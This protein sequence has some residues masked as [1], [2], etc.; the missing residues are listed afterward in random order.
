M[1][2][3]INPVELLQALIRFDTTNPPGNEQECIKYIYNLLTDAGLNPSL[4]SL[5]PNRPNLVCTLKGQ[6]K[7]SPLL[8]YGHSDVVTTKGQI[9]KHPPFEG[10]IDGGCIWGRGALDMKGGIV[11]MITALLKVKAE[12]IN[13]PGDV[14]LAVVSDEENGGIYGAK[15]LVENYPNLF[16]G[17]KYAIGEAGG[18]SIYISGKKFYPVMV[19]E[20]Q[21][22]WLKLTLRGPG[23]HGSMPIRGGAMAKLG[24]ILNILDK[25][26][27]PV[28]MTTTTMEMLKRVQSALPFPQNQVVKGMMNPALSNKIL[29]LMGERGKLFDPMLRNTVSPTIVNGG[30]KVNVIPS[31]ITLQADGRLL[32]GF[33][34]ENMLSELRDILG[35]GVEIEVLKYDQGPPEPDMEKFPLLEDILRKADPEGIPIPFMMSGVTDARFFSKL[36]IQTYGFTPMQIPPDFNILRSAHAADERIPIKGLEFGIEAIFQLLKRF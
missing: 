10:V 5:D 15:F 6:G 33:K 7:S 36:G 1:N 29:K 18:F 22:C 35:E 2:Y 30:D 34:P 12:G 32:P 25:Q 21:I 17:V 13:L 9:W 14:I 28:H 3:P 31:E 11:M 16:E 27:L 20:K 24:R 26:T 8:M 4:Y 23:G 19:A